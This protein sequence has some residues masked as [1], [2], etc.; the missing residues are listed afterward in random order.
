MFSVVYKLLYVLARKVS[1][2]VCI[3]CSQVYDLNIGES[4]W[5]QVVLVHIK[6]SHHFISE[7]PIFIEDIHQSKWDGCCRH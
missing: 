3:H 1:V 7:R 2:F 4:P 6:V 5:Y